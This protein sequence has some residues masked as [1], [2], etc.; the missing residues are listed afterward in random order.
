MGSKYACC[1]SWSDGRA[2]GETDGAFGVVRGEVA[3]MATIGR[4]AYRLA[5][6][7][8]LISTLLF[9]SQRTNGEQDS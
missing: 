2:V 4:A 5:M 3:I 8:V 7:D 9:G 6:Q 1:N